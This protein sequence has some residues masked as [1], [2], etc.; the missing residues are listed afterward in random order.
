MSEPGIC[1]PREYPCPC[2]CGEEDTYYCGRLLS[3]R[4]VESRP[5][6]CLGGTFLCINCAGEFVGFLD[7]ARD[8]A[9]REAEWE[10]G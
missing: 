9:A 7:A 8:A 3:R 6:R 4:N 10:G 5:E 1:E 2:G